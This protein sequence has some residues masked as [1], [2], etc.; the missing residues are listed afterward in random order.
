MRLHA[1]A[2][3]ACLSFA[4]AAAAQTTPV[5]NAGPDQTIACAGQ[6]GTPINLSGMGSSIGPDFSF[7]WSAPGVT[8]NDP[9]SLTPIGV[10]PVGTTEVTLT[11]TFTDPNTAV[12]TSASD[13][14][15]VTVTDTTPPLLFASPDPAQLWPP[16]HK[17]VPVHV[18]VTVFDA[19]DATPAVELVSISSNEADDA[20]GS[21]HTGGDIQGADV[22]TDDVD[23]ALRAERA[24]PGSGR[25][26]S[27]LYRATDLA[28]N[29]SDSLVTVVVPH[30]MGHGAKA[31]GGDGGKNGKKQIDLAKK[32]S[33]KAAKAQL[34]AAKAAA[35]AAQKAYRAALRAAG[36]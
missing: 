17:L 24:G 35:K 25:V 7:L 15:L 20:K 9:T 5:A 34:K 19:C 18:D 31:G 23:F 16:N 26:Y 28:G 22:G 13:T 4:S 10:F 21:G 8:F 36:P 32:A 2:F 27:A 3:A 11:V 12:Q 14:A 1:I 29:H 6:N 30:D 33:V